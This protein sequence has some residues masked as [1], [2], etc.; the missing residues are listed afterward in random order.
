MPWAQI[1]AALARTKVTHGQVSGTQAKQFLRLKGV[2]KLL[3][4]PQISK[5]PYKSTTCT[6]QLK[7]L[8]VN[9]VHCPPASNCC[10]AAALLEIKHK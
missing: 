9:S 2:A 5:N 1:E 7:E 6:K 8:T 4:T 10:L 3:A